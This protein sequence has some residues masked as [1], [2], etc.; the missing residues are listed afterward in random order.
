MSQRNIPR[1]GLGTYS[2]DNR[3]QWRDNVQIALDLGVRHIDTAQ[4][5]GNEQYVGEGIKEAGVARDDIWLSTKTVHHDV[6]SDAEQVP[7]AIDGCLNRLGVDTVDLL[8]VHWPSG[9]YDH[10]TVLPAYDDAYKAGK[11]DNVGLSMPC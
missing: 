2:D 4:V 5:Y 3:K 6:P 8:Y 11:I 10:E 9:V 1:L 7:A